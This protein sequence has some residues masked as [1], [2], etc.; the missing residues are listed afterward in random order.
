MIQRLLILPILCLLSIVLVGCGAENKQIELIL[1]SELAKGQMLQ[2]ID[3]RLNWAEKNSNFMVQTFD[4]NWQI[5]PTESVES[6]SQARQVYLFAKGY[7]VTQENRYLNA[8]VE[9]ADVMLRT[10]FDDTKVLWHSSINRYNTEKRYG[11]KEYSTSFAIFAMAHAY[12]ISQDKRY[13]DA[14]LK[15]WMLGEV[16]IGLTLAREAQ[17]GKLNTAFTNTWSINPLMHL[18]EALLALHDVTQSPS[19]WQDIEFIAQFV[20]NKLMQPQGFLAEYYVNANMPLPISE[21]GYVELGH[22][23]EWAYLLHLAVDKGLDSH[24]RNVAKRLYV[25]AMKTGWDEQAGNLAARSDYDSNLT[26]TTPVWWAQAELMRLTAYSANKNEDF[27]DSARIFSKSTAFALNEY[28]DQFNGGWL[29]KPQSNRSRIQ[30]NKV[31]GYHA[32]AAYSVLQ[33]P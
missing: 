25:Y 31:V 8:M 21:G 13:L 16:S 4:A 28:V 22:Q 20:E 2:L 9:S 12:R 11:P 29:D 14:A 33:E 15:T 26:V 10:M 19:V 1:S 7:D 24:F 18:F 30:L 3:P 6:Y 32:A 23:I 5:A 17:Q 27:D